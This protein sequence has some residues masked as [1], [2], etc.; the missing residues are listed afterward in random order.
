MAAQRAADKEAREKADTAAAKKVM[1]LSPP[2]SSTTRLHAT[3]S[4]SLTGRTVKLPYSFHPRP[5]INVLFSYPSPPPLPA[6]LH[7][8][9]S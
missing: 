8:L 1:T 2:R 9:P 6:S 5:F 4:S 7:R 3:P